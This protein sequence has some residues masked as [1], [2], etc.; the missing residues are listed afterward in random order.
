MEEITLGFTMFA[1][2]A[3]TIGPVM[4]LQILELHPAAWLITI[5]KNMLPPLKH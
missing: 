1:T 5:I 3:I 4:H 2:L